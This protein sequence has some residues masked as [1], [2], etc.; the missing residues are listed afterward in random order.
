MLQFCITD[1]FY[2]VL[3]FGC[4]VANFD[5]GNTDSFTFVKGLFSFGAGFGLELED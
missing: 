2:F 4:E 3:V 1:F 5:P